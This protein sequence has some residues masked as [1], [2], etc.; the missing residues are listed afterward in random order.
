MHNHLVD[1]DPPR[2][3]PKTPPPSLP[4][5]S[6]APPSSPLPPL[7]RSAYPYTP[8]PRLNPY[9]PPPTRLPSMA[10]AQARPQR[11]ACCRGRSPA[12]LLRHPPKRVPPV[13][14][15]PSGPRWGGGRPIARK[16][17]A[18]PYMPPVAPESSQ[19][20]SMAFDGP[21]SHSL[22]PF[23]A[24]TS[25]SRTSTRG[26]PWAAEALATM[27]ASR[28]TTCRAQRRQRASASSAIWIA[29]ALRRSA[30]ARAASAG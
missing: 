17:R 11:A 30:R 27:T 18:P 1:A 19:P 22:T 16:V 10:A 15:G 28:T 9:S 29:S 3:R 2:S 25:R 4:P 6:P 13:Q 24:G 20:P 23:I 5:P 14:A 8:S 21:L 7:P 12:A 26:A